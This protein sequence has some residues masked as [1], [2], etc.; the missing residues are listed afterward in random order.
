MDRVFSIHSHT[1]TQK[2]AA[3]FPEVIKLTDQ[4][5]K[6]K[7]GRGVDLKIQGFLLHILWKLYSLD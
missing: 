5:Q 6:A 4:K 7:R 2:N 1:H 3:N